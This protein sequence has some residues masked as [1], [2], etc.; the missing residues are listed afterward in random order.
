M[1]QS[2]C[3]ANFTLLKMV[4]M[5]IIPLTATLCNLL[6]VNMTCIPTVMRVFSSSPQSLQTHV[7]MIP[8]TVMTKTLFQL[9]TYHHAPLL[10]YIVQVG[11]GVD[12]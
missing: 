3:L 5:H 8:Q 1:T 11:E 9:T 7:K 6:K 2:M 4:F 12:K 10:C